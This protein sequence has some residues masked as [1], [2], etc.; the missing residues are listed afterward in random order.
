[1]WMPSSPPSM[2][3]RDGGGGFGALFLNLDHGALDHL[4]Q[5]GARRKAL[6]GGGGVAGLVE[7]EGVEGRHQVLA[8]R[9]REA[10]QRKVAHVRREAHA[11]EPR[12]DGG[13]FLRRGRLV[14][15]GHHD[16]REALV[17][18]WQI[19]GNEA[20][21]AVALS[22]YANVGQ[23]RNPAS[24]ARSIADAFR[25]LGFADVIERE[26]LTRAGAGDFDG[27]AAWR[28][29]GSNPHARTQPWPRGHYW[30]SRLRQDRPRRRPRRGL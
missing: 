3:V 30:G 4:G 10:R 24:D 27:R 6:Q 12:D 29:V 15:G 2:R 20:A 13:E 16:E 28:V 26:D 1:M 19:D 11:G 5:R 22:A 9:R 23:L 18:K 8:S 17:R 7:A 25:R 14:S 21:V